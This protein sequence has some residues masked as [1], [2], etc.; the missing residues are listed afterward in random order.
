MVELINKYTRKGFFTMRV[1]WAVLEIQEKGVKE[2]LKVKVGNQSMYI[3]RYFIHDKKSF[4]N[5]FNLC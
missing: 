4:A 2:P 5:F 3:S 1:C